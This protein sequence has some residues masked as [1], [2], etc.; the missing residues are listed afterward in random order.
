MQY[1][2]YANFLQSIHNIKLIPS[3]V[4]NL[5][6]KYSISYSHDIAFLGASYFGNLEVVKYLHK[7]G[8][9]ITIQDNL[10]VK[11]ASGNGH[12]EV[13]KYLHKNGAT[14]SSPGNLAVKWASENNHLEVVEYLYKNGVEVKYL[15]KYN[16]VFQPNGVLKYQFRSR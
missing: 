8:A 9:E 7:N 1:I 5:I 12:L 16:A 4:C 14:I 10:A 2:D 15:S 11:W 3:Y 6:V 13:V